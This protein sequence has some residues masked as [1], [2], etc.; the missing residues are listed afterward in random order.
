MALEL[1]VVTGP[2]EPHRL[3]RHVDASGDGVAQ[4]HRPG[5]HQCPSVREI[6][7]SQAHDVPRSEDDDPRHVLPRFAWGGGAECSTLVVTTARAP[8]PPQPWPAR[9][10]RSSAGR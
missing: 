1:E 7:A 6:V 10:R 9:Y 8:R 4:N 5:P 3:R 2:L